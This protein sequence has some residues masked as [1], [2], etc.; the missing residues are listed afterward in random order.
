MEYKYCYSNSYLTK[1]YIEES[2]TDIM[3]LPVYSINNALLSDPKVKWGPCDLD[4][5]LY[6]KKVIFLCCR[7]GHSVVLWHHVLYGTV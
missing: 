3:K 4:G 1:R 2:V 6:A 5:D 7:L